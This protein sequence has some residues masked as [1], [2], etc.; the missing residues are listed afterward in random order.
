[1]AG[2]IVELI[3][4]RVDAAVPLALDDLGGYARV[5]SNPDAI[6]ASRFAPE[7]AALVWQHR[8]CDDGLAHAFFVRLFEKVDHDITFAGLVDALLTTDDVPD[9]LADCCSQ[10][11]LDRFRDQGQ[12]LLVRAAALRGAL[13]L[14]R[15][16]RAGRMP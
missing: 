15:E 1:M 10:I 4:S 12:P 14:V 8:R 9:S 16:Q 3:E 13:A 2:T 6:A 11:L 5:A 7:I